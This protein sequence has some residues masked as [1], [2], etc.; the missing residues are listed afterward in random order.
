MHADLNGWRLYLRDMKAGGNKTMA[1]VHSRED[2]PSCRE[3]LVCQ[4]RRR[5]M[6][7]LRGSWTILKGFRRFCC[8]HCRRWQRRWD[9]ALM[10]RRR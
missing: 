4:H 8:R 9:L 1:Q 10:W 6:S 5:I 3:P 7:T 2:L